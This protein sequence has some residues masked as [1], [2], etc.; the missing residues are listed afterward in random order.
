M[1]KVSRH[2][3]VKSGKGGT[4]INP[5]AIDAE[6]ALRECRLSLGSQVIEVY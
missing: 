2:F 4:F 3:R 5:F 6:E 1:K